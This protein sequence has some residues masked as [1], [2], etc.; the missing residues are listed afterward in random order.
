MVLVGFA[1]ASSAPEVVWSL[2]DNGYDVVAFARRG[3][4]SALHHSRHVVCHEICAPESDVETALSDLRSLMCSLKGDHP[5][6]F[7]LDDTAVWLCNK[8]HPVDRWRLA[9]PQGP[10]A[11]LALNK[12][13]QTT[14]ALKA[15]FNVPH[16]MLA[17]TSEDLIAFCKAHPFPVIL[18]QAEC[19]WTN[20][21]RIENCR[22]ALI[23]R[24]KRFVT[25][26]FDMS[27]IS[28]YPKLITQYV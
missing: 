27:D 24:V 17:R 7:P 6:L 26:I 11:E 10:R 22:T 23:P 13:V 1:E 9:G 15:G 3:Q 19:V 28:K 14:I 8:L 16:T 20:R 2:V 12:C 25:C 4:S 5:I 21:N 18:K